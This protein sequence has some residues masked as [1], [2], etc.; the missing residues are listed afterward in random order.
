MNF[1][2]ISKAFYA[3]IATFIVS[4]KSLEKR[5]NDS[6]AISEGTVG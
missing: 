5:W 3:S 2:R 6:S 1:N 4:H